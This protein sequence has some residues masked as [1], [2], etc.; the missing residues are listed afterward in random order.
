VKSASGWG[1]YRGVSRMTKTCTRDKRR[2]KSVGREEEARRE[3][4]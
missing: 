3:E 4:G 1:E 2:M